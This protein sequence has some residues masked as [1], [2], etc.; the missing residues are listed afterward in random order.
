MTLMIMKH[1]S[2]NSMLHHLPTFDIK[3]DFCVFLKHKI[4]KISSQNLKHFLNM[5]EKQI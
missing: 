4:Y 1:L 5:L 3:N 2:F